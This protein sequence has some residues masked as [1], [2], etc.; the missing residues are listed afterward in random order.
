MEDDAVLSVLNAI[1]LSLSR[2][3]F[4]SLNQGQPL[5]MVSRASYFV[6]AVCLHNNVLISIYKLNEVA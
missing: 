4:I 5:H 2:S 3:I 6:V 1:M